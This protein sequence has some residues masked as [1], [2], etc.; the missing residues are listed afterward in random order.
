ML[1][2]WIWRKITQG[3]KMEL[4]RT[5]RVCVKTHMLMFS[6]QPIAENF[7]CTASILIFDNRN[8]TTQKYLPRIQHFALHCSDKS[9]NYS[10]VHADFVK[11]EIIHNKQKQGKYTSRIV[12]SVKWNVL[13]L[14][15]NTNSS[16][17]SSVLCSKKRIHTAL[18]LV[19]DPGAEW[20]LW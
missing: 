20:W 9:N 2:L 10:D 5:S 6:V 14:N 15:S 8:R 19:T 17:L 16:H 3:W 1:R 7:L 13:I 4:P 11:R 12:N 18:S